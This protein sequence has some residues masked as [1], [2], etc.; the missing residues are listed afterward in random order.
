[1]A[2]ASSGYFYQCC[3]QFS[4]ANVKSWLA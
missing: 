1:M 2:T 4:V 3:L